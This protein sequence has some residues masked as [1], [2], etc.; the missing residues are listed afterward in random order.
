MHYHRGV[1]ILKNNKENAAGSDWVAGF[2]VS[3]FYREGNGLATAPHTGEVHAITSSTTLPGSSFGLN[4]EMGVIADADDA[5]NPVGSEPRLLELLQVT[6]CAPAYVF[7]CVRV[8]GCVCVC[9]CVCVDL[10]CFVC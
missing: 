3:I 10:I 7:V 8:C 2:S 5:F 4:A 9:V 6:S 1:L